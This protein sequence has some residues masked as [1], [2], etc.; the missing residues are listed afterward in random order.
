MRGW[1]PP[2]EPIGRIP[3]RF[4]AAG[5][6]ET[7]TN[8]SASVRIGASLF[9]GGDEACAIERLTIRPDGAGDHRRFP[10]ADLLDLADPEAEADIEGLAECDGWLWVVGSHARTRPKAEKQEDGCIDLEQLAD[11]RDTRSRCLLARLP[12]LPDGAGWQ[13]VKIDGKRRAG[14]MPQTKHGNALAKAL[15]DD[16]L[17]APFTKVPA[18]EGG[19]DVE[20]IAVCGDR[21]ALGLRGPVIGTHA[22]LL[23]LSVTTRKSGRIALNGSPTVRLLAMEGLGIRDLKRHGD[24]LLILAGPTTG[25]SGP[26][27][28][29]RWADWVS[30]PP[31]HDRKVRLHRP[32][33]ILELPFGRGEDHPEGLALMDDVGRAL[34]VIC[35]SPSSERLG[36]D[37]KTITADLFELPA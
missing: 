24:D 32:E 33:R 19:L 4:D 12:L 35:D 29:Y 15:R 25:L 26:C 9:V 14:L 28:V 31:L 2:A 30:D 18:K 36:K 21:V 10:L 7:V 23:E 8:L 37:E 6:D 20:G 16:P 13:P 1:P 11:L 17:L 22:V 3:L 27:A 34:L 5:D